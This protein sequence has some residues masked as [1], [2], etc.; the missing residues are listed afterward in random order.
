MKIWDKRKEQE[1]LNI[2]SVHDFIRPKI[3]DLY[4]CDAIFD[5]FGCS[6]SSND[7]YIVTGSYN[8]I[9]TIYNRKKKKP[10]TLNASR[11]NSDGNYSFSLNNFDTNKLNFNQKVLTTAWHPNQNFLA[12]GGEKLYIFN[13]K[14]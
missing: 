14:I 5:K 11:L 8:D 3:C 12:I 4:T 13:K 6:I 1:P 10:I 2:V 7:R 9:F